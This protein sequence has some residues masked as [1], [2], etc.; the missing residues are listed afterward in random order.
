MISQGPSIVQEL[1]WRA[2]N[3][4]C[5]AIEIPFHMVDREQ[6]KSSFNSKVALQSILSIPAYAILFRPSAHSL[7]FEPNYFSDVIT[8]EKY[9]KVHYR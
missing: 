3:Q 4:K 6:G 9:I 1:L 5:T 8:N 2:M 7:N